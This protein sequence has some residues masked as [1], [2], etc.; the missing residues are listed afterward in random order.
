MGR[1]AL[2]RARR[3]GVAARRRVVGGLVDLEAQVRDHA[4]RALVGD[5]DDPAGAD[6]VLVA[7]AGRALRVLVELEHVAACRRG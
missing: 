1:V 5:V 7:G 2:D 3:A 6:R 4:R